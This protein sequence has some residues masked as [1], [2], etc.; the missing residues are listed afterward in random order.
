MTSNIPSLAKRLTT[1]EVAEILD[2]D[3]PFATRKAR[4]WMISEGIAHRTK[5]GRWYT[6]VGELQQ[7]DDKAIFAEMIVRARRG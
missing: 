4:K 3:P 7:H 1:A 5:S 6:T 2:I